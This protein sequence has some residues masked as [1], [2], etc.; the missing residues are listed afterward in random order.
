MC[1]SGEFLQGNRKVKD[2]QTPRTVSSPI[3]RRNTKLISL[4]LLI[5]ATTSRPSIS[6]AKS[7]SA[8]PPSRSPFLSTASHTSLVD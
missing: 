1:V 3:V 2:T 5:V 7:P 6:E 4:P 8:S